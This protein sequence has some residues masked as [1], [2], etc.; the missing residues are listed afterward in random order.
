MNKCWM[1]DQELDPK[2][3]LI[4]NFNNKL[5]NNF[6]DHFQNVKDQIGTTVSSMNGINATL[7]TQCN[8]FLDI[9]EK[10]INIRKQAREKRL[11]DW[12]LVWW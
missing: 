8:F 9:Y 11:D 5:F 7:E 4:S 3:I 10:I 12:R 6:K 1:S 2:W